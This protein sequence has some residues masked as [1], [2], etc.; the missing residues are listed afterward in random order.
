MVDLTRYNYTLQQKSIEDVSL[1]PKTSS[2]PNY[3]NLDAVFTSKLDQYSSQGVFSQIYEPCL[4]AT[5]YALYCYDVLNILDQVNQAAVIDYV[6]SHYDSNSNIFMD[7]Y[8]Y[9]YLDTDFSQAYYPFSTVLEVNCYAV[10]SL[11][12]LKQMDLI[13]TPAMI[14]FIWSCYNSNEGGFIGQPYSA[15]LSSYFNIST[16]DN[17]YYAIIMLNLLNGWIG[18]SSERDFIINYI[19]SLQSTSSITPRKGGFYNDAN[20]VF[21]SIYYI[22][23][24][25]PSLLS[26]YYGIK[27]LESLGVEDSI[28]VNDFTWYIQNLYENSSDFDFLQMQQ[29]GSGRIQIAY[30]Y[31]FRLDFFGNGHGFGEG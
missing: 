7:K 14:E 24:D 31:K 28:R 23:L 18:H 16:L 25:E 8:A 21:D 22:T 6:M 3:N 9:R 27:G 13:D 10:L 4:Q 19:Q 12:I 1:R 30:L 2:N 20:P 17:T 26:S 15:D 29:Y 11:D 5:Y